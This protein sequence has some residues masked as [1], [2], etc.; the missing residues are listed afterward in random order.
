MTTED[1]GVETTEI[2]T[3]DVSVETTEM[4]TEDPSAVQCNESCP[5]AFS[6]QEGACA[7]LLQLDS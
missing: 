5:S 1:V 7:C 3:E 4:T 6:A 2:T